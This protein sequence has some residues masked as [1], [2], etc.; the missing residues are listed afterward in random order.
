MELGWTWGGVGGSRVGVKLGGVEGAK[1]TDLSGFSR[2]VGTYSGL[3][4]VVKLADP[5]TTTG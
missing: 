1:L 5:N 2:A 4:C 3:G